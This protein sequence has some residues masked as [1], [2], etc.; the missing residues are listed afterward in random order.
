MRKRTATGGTEGLGTWLRAERR[1]RTWD[2]PEM[3]R[4]LVHAAGTD[5]GKLP[6]LDSLI[7]S[8]R[9]WERGSNSLTERYM[10]LY[11]AA[12]RITP[13]QFG[14]ERPVPGAQLVSGPARPIDGA[15]L[16]A[17][18]LS[19][20]ATVP[21]IGEA[22]SSECR[23]DFAHADHDP[24][25]ELAAVTSGDSLLA[26]VEQ[27]ALGYP[28]PLRGPASKTSVGPEQTTRIQETT[29]LFRRWDNEF[30]G[31]LRRRA[32]IGQLSEASELLGGPF[33]DE[34]TGRAFFAAITDLTQLVG[35]I[36]FDLHLP[37]TAERYFLLGMRLA[38]DAGDRPQ[39]AR[40][41]YCLSRLMVDI[42]EQHDALDLAQ[43]GLYA[44]RRDAP[45][46]ATAMLWV[47]EARA[48]AC[49]GEAAD[50][51]RSLGDAREAFSHAGP[52]TDPA[53]SKFFDETGLSGLIGAAL[54]DLALADPDH[55]RDHATAAEPWIARAASDRPRAYL[56]SK[57]LDLD[58]LALT[59]LL[60][61]D[62]DAAAEPAT[63][64]ISMARE[65]TSARVSSRLRRTARLAGQW[66]P[67]TRS[68]ADLADQLREQ[69]AP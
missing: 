65:V 34:R 60:L 39:V 33:R 13:D 37:A 25:V 8:I 63:A 1:A 54:R 47:T 9:R 57:I 61:G 68:A 15:A 23:A 40:L 55:A 32:V 20:L 64:A 22:L 27:A 44:M 42:G 21:R 3:A 26:A 29:D 10:L 46:K 17:M 28:A 14:V 52:G 6:R 18:P 12:L 45:P 31:G 5:R 38:R 7:T 69:P 48:H 16:P 50:C 56:R 53:W 30:G 36:S 43:A 19:A 49:L 62:P 58:G 2:V 41:L 51:H 35:W 59:K 66:F 11:C 67:G 4:Q 24:E